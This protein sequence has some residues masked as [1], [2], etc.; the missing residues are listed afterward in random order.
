L[1]TPI[2]SLLSNQKNLDPIVQR[3][4]EHIIFDEDELQNHPL[5][6]QLHHIP[7]AL[8][9]VQIEANAYDFPYL[10]NDWGWK[11]LP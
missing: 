6:S 9:H 7:P 5:N 3:N 10:I 2:I 8:N 11:Q 1:G 4:F